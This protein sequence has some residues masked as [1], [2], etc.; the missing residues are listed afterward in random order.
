MHL[1]PGVAPVKE[2]KLLTFSNDSV[3]EFFNKYFVCF[4]LNMESPEGI[5]FA[6]QNP[7]SSYPTFMFFDQ[8]G[9]KITEQKGYREPDNFLEIG[10]V[11][12]FP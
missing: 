10:K 6:K 11:D 5:E 3:G 4:K 9:K 2:W 1:L 8:Y 12:N 7:V